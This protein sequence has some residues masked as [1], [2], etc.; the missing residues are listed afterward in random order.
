MESMINR[1]RSLFPRLDVKVRESKAAATL[2]RRPAYDVWVREPGK[3]R[4]RH[5]FCIT[6]FAPEWVQ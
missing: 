2:A 5:V 4:G 3:S 1:A 6:P